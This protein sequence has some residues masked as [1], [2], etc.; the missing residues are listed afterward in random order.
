MKISSTK[1]EIKPVSQLISAYDVS[2]FKNNYY[3]NFESAGHNHTLESIVDNDPVSLREHFSSLKQVANEHG[4]TEVLVVCEPTGGYEKLLLKVARSFGFK[5]EYVSGEASSKYKVIE[6]NDSGKN[7]IKD[8]RVI[9]ALAKAGKTLTC[10]DLPKEYQV[11]RRLSK[12]YERISLDIAHLKNTISTVIE[13]FFPG[14]KISA[15]QIYSK[16][17]TTVINLYGLNPYKISALSFNRFV[18]EVEKVLGKTCTKP[19]KSLLERIFKSSVNFDYKDTYEE[20][21][22]ADTLFLQSLFKRYDLLLEQKKRSKDKVLIAFEKTKEFKK[23]ES[24]GTGLFSIARI[25]SETG[26]LDS[27]SCI[28]QVIRYAGLNLIE[29]Q[30]GTYRGHVRVSKKGNSLLRKILGQLVFSSFIKKGSVYSDYYFKKKEQKGGFYALTCTMRKALK[31]LFGIHKSN[32]S[33]CLERVLDQEYFSK[34][35]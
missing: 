33:F 23:F 25:I 12:A 28:E 22:E 1:S 14:V 10:R 26:P 6:T 34:V 3:S 30:S 29:R 4:M 13:E 21:I 24:I 20:V 27:F 16:T 19:Q 2:K 8:A 31:M 18:K 17:V 7:D 32:Q 35:A 11:L 5:T 9:F 15:S